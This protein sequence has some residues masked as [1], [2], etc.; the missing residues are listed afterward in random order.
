MILR[1]HDEDEVNGGGEGMVEVAGV[2]GTTDAGISL[3]DVTVEV[4]GVESDVRWRS[5]TSR[6]TGPRP[7]PRPQP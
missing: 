4:A 1:K 7:Q 3:A 2:D 6:L 5:M